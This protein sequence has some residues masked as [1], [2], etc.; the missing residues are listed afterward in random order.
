MKKKMATKSYIATEDI[1]NNL[2][3]ISEF[4]KLSSVRKDILKFLTLIT[5]N[6]S[7]VPFNFFCEFELLRLKFDMKKLII[8]DVSEDQVRM[9]VGIFLGIKLF[10]NFIFYQPWNVEILQLSDKLDKKVKP[11]IWA[12][13]SYFY[14]AFMKQFKHI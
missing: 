5:L 12:Y 6:N 2:L 7:P 13:S 9:I 11:I 1:V 3:K 4:L 14:T 10:C 8:L